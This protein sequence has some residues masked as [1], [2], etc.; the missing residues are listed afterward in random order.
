MVR[1]TSSRDPLSSSG[2]SAAGSQT[3]KFSPTVVPWNS[4]GATPAIANRLPLT[5]RVWPSTPGSLPKRVRH[6]PYEMT[7]AGSSVGCREAPDLR[8]EAKRGEI[9]VGDQQAVRPLDLP[10]LPEVERHAAKREQIAK[11]VQPR[12]QV[13]VLE[14][15][16]AE[17]HARVGARFHP[18]KL[19]RAGHAGERLQQPRLDPGKDDGV[20]ADAGAERHDD[21]R[22]E[23]RHAR[24]RAGGV[25]DVTNRIT[26]H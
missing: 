8:L 25:P 20:D 15:R 3:S 18:M 7:I 23:Q 9:I 16:D 5:R 26:N 12:A 2:A 13:V 17:V 11:R 4:R 14:P 6:S 21:H 19:R 24:D 1:S 22:R 10:R